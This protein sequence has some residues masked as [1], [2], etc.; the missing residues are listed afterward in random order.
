M[1]GGGLGPGGGVTR[2]PSDSD[3][4]AVPVLS[5]YHLFNDLFD[6]SGKPFDFVRNAYYI[7]AT[8]TTSSIVAESAAGIEII[9]L[10]ATTCIKF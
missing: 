2:L 10:S 1:R 8:L 9:Q 4:P 6:C 3:A 7:E 5:G